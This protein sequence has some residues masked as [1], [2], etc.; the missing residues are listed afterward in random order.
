MALEGVIRGWFQLGDVPYQMNAVHTDRE[1][2]NEGCWACSSDNFEG[3]EVFVCKL[4]GGPCGPDKFHVQE[5]LCHRS[6]MVV[7]AS[8][9]H[10]RRTACALA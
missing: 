4:A 10:P 6:S 5:N 7:R 1:T 2:K 9:W 8:A 3:T